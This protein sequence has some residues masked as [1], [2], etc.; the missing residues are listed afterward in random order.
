MHLITV[1]KIKGTSVKNAKET[2]IAEYLDI[3]C[4][5]NKRFDYYDSNIIHIKHNSST[6]TQYC[7]QYNVRTLKQLEKALLG[8]YNNS[9][10]HE[11]E[12]LTKILYR[13]ILMKHM[14]IQ[15]APLYINHHYKEVSD[16]ANKIL[17]GKITLEPFKAINTPEQLVE[18]IIPLLKT[19]ISEIKESLDGILDLKNLLGQPYDETEVFNSCEAHFIDIT[20]HTKGKNV[21][22]FEVDRHF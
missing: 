20:R 11:Q 3:F 6:F 10:R 13:L 2:L 19:G 9:L 5:E 1:I 18:A 15:E 7:K 8:L 22:Y 21:Y 4:G 17:K 16:L 14:S 12:E